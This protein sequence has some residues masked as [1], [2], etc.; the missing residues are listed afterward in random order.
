MCSVVLLDQVNV[1]R[2]ETDIDSRGAAGG[3]IGLIALTFSLALAFV[4]GTQRGKKNTEQR[5]NARHIASLLPMGGWHDSMKTGR[6][7]G[8]PQFG[9]K[10]Q[11]MPA[12]KICHC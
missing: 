3:G 7:R 9:I 10:I 1:V 4:V 11:I 5:D 8:I 6:K 12:A 2:P